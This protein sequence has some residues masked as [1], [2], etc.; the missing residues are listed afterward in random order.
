MTD[1]PEAGREAEALATAG[2]DAVD[3]H[4]ARLLNLAALWQRCHNRHDQPMR[5]RNRAINNAPAE[6]VYGQMRL[7]KQPWPLSIASRSRP[8][9]GQSAESV[10][11]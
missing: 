3:A 8:W 6:K 4:P 11:S 2:G 7:V 1:I 9:S 5:Q 10:G